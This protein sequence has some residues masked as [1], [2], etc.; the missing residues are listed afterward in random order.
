MQKSSA[1]KYHGELLSRDT[2]SIQI[3][4]PEEG[5]VKSAI[6]PKRTRRPPIVAA[7]FGAKAARIWSGRVAAFDPKR[8]LRSER[9]TSR[10][11]VLMAH[12]SP[13]S[14]LGTFRGEP[15]PFR[16]GGSDAHYLSLTF[17]VS[18]NLR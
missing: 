10:F 8:T 16:V 11:V 5:A 4:V 15:H 14:R 3:P 2:K 18:R 1:G 6:G 13:A 9:L 7:V 12:R 17:V